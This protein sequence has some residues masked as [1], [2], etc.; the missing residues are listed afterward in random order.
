MLFLLIY[1]ACSSSEVEEGEKKETEEASY[2]KI[3]GNTEYTL[4]ADTESL[5]R[6]PCMGWGIYDDASGAVAK[7]DEYWS[8]QGNAAQKYASFFYI[9]WRWSE[10]E[11]KEGKYAWIYNENYKKLIQGAKDRG[12]KLAFRIYNNSKDNLHQSTPDYVREAGAEGFQVRANLWSDTETHWTPYVDDLIFRQKYETFLAAFAKEYDNSEIVDCLDGASFG[13]WGEGNDLE[14]RPN[15]SEKRQD[16]L[17][18]LTKTHK[19][20]FKNIILLVGT[21]NE[22]GYEL[23]QKIAINGAGYG[24]RCDGLGSHWHSKELQ[25]KLLNN[26]PSTLLIG[27]S[28]YWG[29]NYETGISKEMQNDPEY[30]YTSWR[31]V[32]DI[33]CQQA[34]YQ[35]YNTLDLR[36]HTETKGWI[37]DAKDLVGK[38]IS[39]GGYRLYPSIVSAPLIAQVDSEITLAH[40]WRNLATGICPNHYPNWDY[41]YKVAFSL[42]NY[43]GEITKI[44]I[45]PKAEP[46]KFLYSNPMDY[47]LK[48]SLKNIPQGTYTLCLAIIDSK[49]KNVPGL[50]L[51]TMPASII[52]NGWVEISSLNIE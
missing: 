27:E 8:L 13:Q 15:N 52:N 32:Y 4:T 47:H 25:N 31:Q 11:P 33:T 22:F 6:N 38:F 48:V 34:L 18:W 51:A 35:H 40:Q 3:A 30:H 36:T 28:C 46:S 42:I 12:L 19:K 37:K 2:F 10:M 29:G 26:Y 16:A 21:G 45:D 14:L 44:F 9:R 41:K 50:K 39:L 20:Y 23:E 49:R 1:C 17:N 43:Q 5:L 24:F 7:A